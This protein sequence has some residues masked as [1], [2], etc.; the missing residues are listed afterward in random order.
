MINLK[1]TKKEAKN[2]HKVME[3]DSEKYPWG[4]SLSFDKLQI[5]KIKVLQ[6]VSAGDQVEIKAIGKV[7]EVRVTDYENTDDSYRHVEIQ[8]QKISIGNRD[9][10][11][12]AFEEE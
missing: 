4:T 12:K 1:M 2:Q 11:D 9:E 3:V 10:E 8:I 5:N 7:T 6:T